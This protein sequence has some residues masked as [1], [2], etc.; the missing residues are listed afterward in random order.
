MRFDPL[1]CPKCG[2][3]P[4]RILATVESVP[5]LDLQ[6]D[7]SFEF[8][9]SGV[10]W[11]TL[12][13][14]VTEGQV[15][16]YCRHHHGYASELIDEPGDETIRPDADEPDV[17]TALTLLVTNPGVRAHLEQHDPAL[18]TLARNAMF[19]ASGLLPND[20]AETKPSGDMLQALRTLAAA[21]EF[22]PHWKP[23]MAGCLLGIAR[24]AIASETGGGDPSA[25]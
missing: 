22:Y 24:T 2:E 18:L 11:E 25:E 20:N 5:R 4:Y 8:D 23:E 12:A 15:T 16:L 21:L 19:E 10:S 7:G 17:L 13:P 3:G 14:L 9:P 6:N 1:Q